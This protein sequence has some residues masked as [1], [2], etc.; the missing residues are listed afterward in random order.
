MCT[1]HTVHEYVQESGVTL[2]ALLGTL[3]L[4]MYTIHIHGQA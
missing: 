3:L 4:V 1:T 2:G